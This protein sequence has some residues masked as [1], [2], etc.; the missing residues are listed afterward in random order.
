MLKARNFAS[1]QGK[2]GR[3]SGVDLLVNEHC[4]GIFNAV[5]EQKDGFYG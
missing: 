5:L 4:E 3:A 2:N 1:G